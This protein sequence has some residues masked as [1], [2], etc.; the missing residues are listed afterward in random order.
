MYKQQKEQGF[1]ILFSILISAVMLLISVGIFNIVKKQS[2]LSSFSRESQRA[3]YAADAALEC[4]L[5]NDLNPPLT[6][7]TQITKFPYTQAGDVT[8]GCSEDSN[9][10]AYDLDNISE[11]SSDYEIAYGFNY[12]SGS[13]ED[14]GCAFVLVEKTL[15]D[16]VDPNVY[17]TRVTAIGFNRCDSNGHPN[18]DDP[19]ILERRLS[20]TY[21]AV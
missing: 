15:D 14:S 13:A 6:G 18:Y 3:F 1:I 8:I 19:N 2:I 21:T 10:T 11:L 7:S 16:T 17:D 20:A 4:A 12:Q 9:I 5:R